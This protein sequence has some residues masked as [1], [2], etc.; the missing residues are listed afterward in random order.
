M[1]L[2]KVASFAIMILRDQRDLSTFTWGCTSV[3]KAKILLI[4]SKR[5]SKSLAFAIPLGRRYDVELAVTGQQA[6]LILTDTFPDVIVLNAASMRTSGKRICVALRHKA[7]DLPIIHVKRPEETPKKRRRGADPTSEADMV[8]YLPFTSRKL[9]NRIDRFVAAKDGEVLKAGPFQLNLK[10]RIL[11]TTSDE[12]R[13]TPKLTVLLEL[14]MR[15][16]N[17]VLARRFLMEKVWN[18]DYLG[19]TRTL[20]VHI[21]WIREA[22][23]E[24]P[25]NPIFLRT[26]RGKGYVLDLSNHKDPAKE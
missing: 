22:I 24:R 3:G 19:D 20:D 11:T 4:E 6:L 8:L 2:G 12:V 10:S 21:R 1:A 17:E 7:P 15:H 14:F 13:L 23:E 25:S 18:T 5:A 9:Y 26:V 16:P